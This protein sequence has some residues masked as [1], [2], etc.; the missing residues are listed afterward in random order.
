MKLFKFLLILL[1]VSFLP[2]GLFAQNSIDPQDSINSQLR[3]SISGKD[4]VL[5]H[6]HNDYKQ[7]V[8]FYQ[9][10]AQQLYSIEADVF[11][12]EGKLLVGHN[13]ENLD[14]NGNLEDLYINPIVKLFK[15]NG[16]HAWKNS[17]KKL[18]FVVELKSDTKPT[19]NKLISKLEKYPK[20]FDPQENPDAVKVVIT[21]KVPA[22]EDFEEYPD[23][24]FFDG[25]IDEKYSSRQLDRVA[26][27]SMPLSDYADW[28]GKGTFI[29][30]QKKRV[31]EVIKKVHELG[32][33]IRFWGTPDEI[34]AWNTF[35]RMGVDIINTDEIEKCSNFFDDFEDKNYRI[36]SNKE[37]LHGVTTTDRLDKI[38]S[39]FE[40]FDHKEIQLSKGIDVYEPTF[41]ADG[42]DARID[43]V[44]LM[45]GDGMGVA[46][47]NAAETANKKGLSLL[48]LKNV[49]LQITTPRGAYTAE[50]AS[51]GS[52]LATGRA[53]NNRYISMTAEGKE[54][55]AITDF[56]NNKG[57]SNGVITSGNLADAT[58]AVF[59]GHA[60]D[61]N[62]SDKITSYLPDGKLDLLV[63][64][65]MD[66]LK[67]RNDGKNLIKILRKQ[68]R[69]TNDF[70]E[71]NKDNKKTIVADAR[72]DLATKQGT[73]DLLAKT[74]RMGIKKLQKRS[75]KGFF[76]MVEGAKVD[77][78]GHANSLPG[79]VNEMLSFDAAIKEALKFADKDGHTLV[80]VTADH[81]T[82]GLSLIDGDRHLG[83]ITGT[84]TT[85]DHTPLMVPVFA[86]GPGSQNFRGVYREK[87]I[88]D[89]MKELL[90]L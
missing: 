38:T 86:Y 52:A 79:T 44:I 69:V 19:L 57:L 43:N 30:K 89:K 87:E 46:Q 54:A 63:G 49:G 22:P 33:P 17:D 50:S 14:V 25:L 77:Y 65:G 72:F 11:L 48:N 81:E 85:E 27:F 84:F 9:A 8:P 28:N 51:G 20:I 55:P 56:S 76:L 53:T 88:Y 32:K 34:T 4:R 3:D 12:K 15:Q 45:I 35:Y 61:R 31:Q 75:D 66:V 80:I 13:R 21:G 68:Y 90:D 78:A 39:Q 58:P 62:M 18:Q 73:L 37:D 36:K 29:S 70:E 60:T 59:Y 83:L 23:F 26:M 71:I 10:Y 7:R 16:G 5:I 1:S 64:S 2:G 41:E 24:I 82:G 74:T 40:G 6:S 47:I 67:D 42:S